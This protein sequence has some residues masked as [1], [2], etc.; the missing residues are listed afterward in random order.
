M[1]PPI[2]DNRISHFK[3][4]YANSDLISFK[5]VESIRIN[6]SKPMVN[7]KNNELYDF[8]SLFYEPW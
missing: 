2:L 1:L 8:L 4:V 6:I 3:I 7:V 5:I